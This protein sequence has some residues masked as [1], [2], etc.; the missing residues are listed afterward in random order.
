MAEFHMRLAPT[1]RATCAHCG[2]RIPDETLRISRVIMSESDDTVR[3]THHF[4]AMCAA[5]WV[6]RPND[7]CVMSFHPEIIEGVQRNGPLATARERAY[8]AFRVACQK[9]TQTSSH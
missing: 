1:G 3:F 5:Q 4:H 2:K 6:M 9:Q 7:T 8:T